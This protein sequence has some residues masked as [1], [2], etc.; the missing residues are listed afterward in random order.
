MKHNNSEV[1]VRVGGPFACFTRPEFTTER[2]SYPV[3]TPPAA[4]GVLKSIFWKPEFE[5]II[6]R[7]WV[8]TDPKWA[9]IRRNEL[10]SRASVNNHINIIDDRTQ[11]HTLFLRDVDYVVFAR[12]LMMEHAT[13]PA[14]KYL[15]QFRR[16]LD[17]GAF[18]SPPYL[19]L[20]EHTA[21]FSP[22]DLAEV[23]PKPGLTIPVGPMSLDLGYYGK[24]GADTN[25]E[26]FN[27]MVID[28]VLDG[29]PVPERFKVR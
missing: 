9:S 7:I 8:L 22:V 3:I 29:I 19:G 10:K 24:G 16:R 23:K 15:D 14:K 20:R 25:P 28:G 21:T 2:V 17:R 26:F 13:D 18:F 11:R 27:A 5:W 12:P 4:V 6:T 1:A